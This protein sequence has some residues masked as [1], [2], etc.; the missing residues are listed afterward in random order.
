[1]GFHSGCWD[2][3]QD[4]EPSYR[5]AE[6]MKRAFEVDVLVCECGVRREVISCITDRAG[7]ASSS[8]GAR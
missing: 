4:I 5:W 6:L 1:M 2:L 7:Y 3:R 8:A